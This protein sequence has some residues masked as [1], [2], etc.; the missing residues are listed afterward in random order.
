[1]PRHLHISKSTDVWTTIFL[2]QHSLIN[3][4]SANSG[5][6]RVET[7]YGA[8]SYNPCNPP[9][10]G[11]QSGADL[12]PSQ[13]LLLLPYTS[14][15]A[16]IP[17]VKYI[18]LILVADLTGEMSSLVTSTSPHYITIVQP[19]SVASPC[20]YTCVT[21]ASTMPGCFVVF[22]YVELPLS[23]FS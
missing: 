5:I 7:F 12:Y 19:L 9:R 1:M 11:S 13:S 8:L 6:K 15:L 16:N 17:T 18:S 14:I 4:I 10:K 23:A 2:S 21:F 3:C 22:C 20:F